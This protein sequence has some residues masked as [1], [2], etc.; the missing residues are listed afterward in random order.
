MLAIVA[1]P[2]VE[3]VFNP[4]PETTSSQLAVMWYS[5]ASR[6]IMTVT[7]A[8]SRWKVIVEES[9]PKYSTIAPVPPLTVRISASLRM[10]SKRVSTSFR[11]HH[12]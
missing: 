6:G 11:Q 7:T 5:Y 2:V 1:P 3:T 12:H 10:T 9:L 4:G 8:M